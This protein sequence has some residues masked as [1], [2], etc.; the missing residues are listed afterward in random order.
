MPSMDIIYDY[1]HLELYAW[2]IS[3]C[4]VTTMIMTTGI[5]SIQLPWTM[6]P[7]PSCL[8]SVCNFPLH[9]WWTY[10]GLRCILEFYFDYLSC[11]CPSILG[12]EL[13]R[14]T[15]CRCCSRE[16]ILVTSSSAWAHQESWSHFLMRT[17]CECRCTCL[18]ECFMFVDPLMHLSIYIL[19]NLSEHMNNNLPACMHTYYV[20]T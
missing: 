18:C 13:C 19:H 4:F 7:D 2:N 5:T 8:S 10:T 6:L 16:R 3:L 11:V 15:G 17:M 12:N 14:P 20:Q 9:V 1:P